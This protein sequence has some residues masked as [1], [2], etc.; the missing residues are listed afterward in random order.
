MNES[1]RSELEALINRHS[2]ENVCGNTP[3]FIV[4]DFIMGCLDAFSAATK[5]REAWYG[6]PENFSE[7]ISA[8]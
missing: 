7:L 4:A 2:L 3:D 8:S 1:F 6:R 5:R